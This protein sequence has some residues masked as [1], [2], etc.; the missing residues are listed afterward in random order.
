ME[1]VGVDNTTPKIKI[2]YIQQHTRS[3]AGV[4]HVIDTVCSEISKKYGAIF[5]I[6]VLYTSSHANRPPGKPSYHEIECLTHG[7]FDLMRTCR[8]VVKSKDY[9]LVIIPQIEPAV[10]VMM[11]C[12]GIRRNFAVYLHGNPQRER[13]HWKAKLL[14]FIMKAYFL[15][16]LS[17]VFGTSPRQLESFNTMF[18]SRVH[19][20]WLPNPVRRFEMAERKQQG[21]QG[22]V[23]FINVGRFDYQKGQDILISAFYELTKTHRNVKL[24]VVGYGATEANLREMVD[25][26]NLQSVVSFEYFPDSPAPALIESDVYISTSRWEGWSLA[27]C[28]ALRFGLPVISTNCDF[29]PSDIL[30]DSRLGKLIEEGAIKQLAAAMSYYAD[31]LDDEM[32]HAD[33][34][35]NYIGRFDVDRVV[36][37]HANALLAATTSRVLGKGTAIDFTDR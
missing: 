25:K 36:V 7:R 29:G 17:N 23:T 19:H 4:E 33:Y 26:L 10:I 3:F 6:D 37:E 14:F 28:E 21:D 15:R 34:R 13:S 5:D 11:A 1:I 32:A 16:R 31:H 30:V 18:R 8:R 27:I 24:K 20:T 12:L 22:S 9:A 35:K 2:L